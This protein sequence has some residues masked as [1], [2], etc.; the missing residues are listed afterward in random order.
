MYMTDIDIYV[1]Y[2]KESTE[3]SKHYGI[4]AYINETHAI[5]FVEMPKITRK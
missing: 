5:Y 1:T 3:K 2:T 4:N